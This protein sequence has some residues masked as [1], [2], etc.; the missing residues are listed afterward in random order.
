[1]ISYGSPLCPVTHQP[2]KHF[3]RTENCTKPA[4]ACQSSELASHKHGVSGKNSF[5]EDVFPTIRQ[6]I[7]RE[8]KPADVAALEKQDK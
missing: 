1:M 7:E 3:C 2:A 8:L 5:W 4:F 6:I